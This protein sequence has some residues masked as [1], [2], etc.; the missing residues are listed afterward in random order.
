MS[1]YIEHSGYKIKPTPMPTKGKIIKKGWPR[2]IKSIVNIIC[3]GFILFI[4]LI[5]VLI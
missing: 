5:L 4:I 3:T 2:E 1:K